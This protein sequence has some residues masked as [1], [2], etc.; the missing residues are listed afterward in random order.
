VAASIGTDSYLCRGW[1]M[2]KASR[3]TPPRLG[4]R[5]EARGNS[6]LLPLFAFAV[7]FSASRCEENPDIVPTPLA[8]TES[9]SVAFV[10]AECKF[11]FGMAWRTRRCSRNLTKGMLIPLARNA[12]RQTPLLNAVLTQHDTL[13]SVSSR[14]L[15]ESKLKSLLEFS[16]RARSHREKSRART[17]DD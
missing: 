15:F 5:Y 12:N 14:L 17:L 3:R 13:R 9:S 10:F 8:G 7:C 2:A 11:G 16:S 6:A 1:K 4:R